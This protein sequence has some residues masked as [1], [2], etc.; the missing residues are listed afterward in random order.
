VTETRGLDM[1]EHELAAL[2]ESVSG[3]LVLPVSDEYESARRVW[4]G[5]IDRHPLGVL[6]CASVDD[7]RAGVAFARQHGIP[8]AVRGGGHNVAGHGTVEAGL[9]LDLA[10]MNE[11]IVD[12]AAG[13]ASVGAGATWGQL[14]AATQRF[15][16]AVPGGMSSRTGVS[17][18]ALG[19]GYGWIRNAFGLSCS[20]ILAAD[21]VTADSTVVETDGERHPDLLWALRGGG[22]NVGVVTRF[23][24]Q[25]HRVG[26]EVY[27]LLVYHDARH[28]GATRAMRA[29]RQF[30]AKAP[31]SVSLMARLGVVADDAAGFAPGSAGVPF[32]AFAGVFLGDPDEGERLLGPL[33]RLFPDPLRDESGR[34]QYVDAQRAFDDEYP[35]GGRYY[36]KS[37]N[38][39]E[40]SDSA[41][42][43]VTATGSS[44]ASKH[45]TV[46]V[47]HIAG[48]AAQ[49]VDGAFTA[50]P[51]FLVHPAAI[52]E[53][54]HH[55]ARNIAWVRGLVTALAPYSDH[56]RYLNFAGFEEEGDRMLRASYGPNYDRLA[57]IKD[58]WDQHN[59]FHLNQNVLPIVGPFDEAAVRTR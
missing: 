5:V 57:A 33:R 27:F 9:V 12:E 52:W 22:G 45:S 32:V 55:D 8:L 43:L 35:E 16:L 51:G 19:G 41:I 40:L 25:L 39:V 11:I 10:A 13:R 4:N 36:W 37:T 21:V 46:D 7:V 44:P 42:D 28:S 53:D 18:L 29:F 6:R 30:C 54:P 59:L 56:S 58:E 24:F 48:A 3:E 38:V 47:W 2:G 50:R 15:G 20:S 31:Y 14:D 26:P 1:L 34:V 23:D 17:G 49:P